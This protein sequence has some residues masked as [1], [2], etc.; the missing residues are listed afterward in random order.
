MLKKKVTYT[1]FNGEEVTE[2]LYFNLTKAEITEMELTT[3]GGLSAYIEQITKEED[4]AE[5][6]KIMKELVLM[7]YG[8]KSKDGRVFKK[9]EELRKE[10]SQTQMYSDVFM[11]LA[12]DADAAVK[13]IT[14]IV[15]RDLGQEAL[16]AIT[17]GA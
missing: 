10:F 16:K 1:N 11:E 13:F 9:T 7:S 17:V 4:G 5:L 2:E 3:P 15:P 14:G 6:V 12:T 8:V